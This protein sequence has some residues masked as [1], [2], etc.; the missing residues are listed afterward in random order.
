MIDNELLFLSGNDIPFVEAKLVI[1]QPT[2]KEIA[3]IGE[4]AFFTGCEL[5]NF[6]KDR[7]TEKDKSN[8]I[9]LDDFDILMSMINNSDKES[10]LQENV[11]NLKSLLLLIFP[12][13]E[14]IYTID[15]IVFIKEDISTAITKN[16]FKA[17]KE[18]IVEMFNLKFT[19]G[20]Q[21]DDYNPAGN[22]AK[23]IAD[24]LKKRHQKLSELKGDSEKIS[25]LSRYVSILSV[26]ERKDLNSLMNYTVYQLFDE[27]QRYTLKETSD[28]TFKL[29]MVG[30]KDVKDAEDWMK[31][32][33]N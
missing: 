33:H 19:T 13:Y 30:A 32:L 26:G 16:N 4:K 11:N 18:I 21:K 9:N 27:F 10:K 29:R 1:H 6:S 23:Q 22:L 14:I 24:K 15:A 28:M 20:D 25:I 12:D 17:L 2:L 31:D 5:L 8:L 3:L 7:L